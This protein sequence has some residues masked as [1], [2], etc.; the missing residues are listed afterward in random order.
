[1]EQLIVTPLR[2]AEFIAGKTIP[3][4]IIAFAQMMVVTAFAIYWFGIP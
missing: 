2:P 4:V 3:Y 1:M